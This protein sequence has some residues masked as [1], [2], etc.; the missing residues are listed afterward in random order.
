MKPL[1]LVSTVTP[2]IVAVFT[3]LA[4][5]AAG[6]LSAAGGRGE[7][8]PA[9]LHATRA[10]T[11]AAAAGRAS[12]I[13]RRAGPLVRCALPL[14]PRPGIF[15]VVM[16]SC[17]LCRVCQCLAGQM[18]WVEMIAWPGRP[19]APAA[20]AA[21]QDDSVSGYWSWRLL[22][23]SAKAGKDQPD[24]CGQPGHERR[25]G[26]LPSPKAAR[27]GPHRAAC[28]TRP[29]QE[30]LCCLITVLLLWW[31]HRPWPDAVGGGC[32]GDDVHVESAAA[33]D[34]P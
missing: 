10:A 17:P 25:P 5:A 20:S 21:V 32:A 3:V 29:G 15:R 23:H 4:A 28:R 31:V 9:E 30:V 33:A 1:L 16:T 8:A 2:A 14:P 7:E 27:P 19:A 26:C 18:G 12:S 34:D 11:A 6:L 24:S 13:R 22:R